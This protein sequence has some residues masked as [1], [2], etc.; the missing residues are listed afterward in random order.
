MYAIN[1]QLLNNIYDGTRAIVKYVWPKT[2]FTMEDL[3]KKQLE[4]QFISPHHPKVLCIQR[5]LEKVRKIVGICPEAMIK[6]ALPIRVETAI[7][8][9]TK[10]GLKRDDGAEIAYTEFKGYI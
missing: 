2:M 1:T 8:S 3:I 4:Q 6:V 10:G 5:A 7:D 9:W